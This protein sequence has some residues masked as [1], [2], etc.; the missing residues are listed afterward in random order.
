MIRQILPASPSPPTD[1]ARPPHIGGAA[2]FITLFLAGAGLGAVLRDQPALT[3][4]C[5]F[6]ALAA[7]AAQLARWWK[8]SLSGRLPSTRRLYPRRWGLKGRV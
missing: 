6:V 8:L 7:V 5:L 4:F 2:V 3:L 1:R